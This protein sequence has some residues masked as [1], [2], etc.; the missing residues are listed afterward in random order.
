VKVQNL[1]NGA[2]TSLVLLFSSLWVTRLAVMGF[3][4]TVIAP[5]I[6]ADNWMKAL[7]SKTLSTRAR[8]SFAHH[9]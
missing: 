6:S 8:L 2:R 4:L 5:H 1:H 3:D 9:Q 7:L